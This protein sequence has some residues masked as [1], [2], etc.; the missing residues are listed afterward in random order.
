MVTPIEPQV[1]NTPKA[2]PAF[3]D[4]RIFDCSANREGTRKLF[5]IL[6]AITGKNNVGM[7]K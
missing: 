3:L 4:E 2:I 6:K 7:A 1:E 5:P